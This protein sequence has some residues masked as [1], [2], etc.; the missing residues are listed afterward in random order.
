MQPARPSAVAGPPRL[1]RLGQIAVTAH[2]VPRATAFWRDVLGV[3]FLFEA[4]GPL[5][6]F[7]CG[8]VRVMLSRPSAAEFDHPSSVLYFQVADIGA[9]HARLAAA[10][11][12]FRGPPHLVAK[13]PDHELWMAFFA[14][15]E[16]NTLALMSKVRGA[17]T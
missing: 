5:A 4:P 14:D 3:R 13:L 9:E 6:F 1:S 12:S 11:V 16:G 8:G 2:D 15:S 7:D 17:A 10:G